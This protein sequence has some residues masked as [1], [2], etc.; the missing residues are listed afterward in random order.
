MILPKSSCEYPHRNWEREAS[1][2]FPPMA[3]LWSGEVAPH[4]MKESVYIN[5]ERREALR[6][7]WASMDWESVAP[8]DD[9]LISKFEPREFPQR[10]DLFIKRRR[11]RAEVWDLVSE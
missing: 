4:R 7:E 5:Q 11:T 9:K 2:C 1:A 8:K 10:E 6:R 3:A